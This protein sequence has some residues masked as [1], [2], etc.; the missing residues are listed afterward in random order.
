MNKRSFILMLIVPFL[1]ALN[2]VFGKVLVD[3]L[4]PYTI[5]AGRFTVA[6]IIFGLWIIFRK[7]RLPRKDPKF[8]LTLVLISLAS[9]V[10]YNGTLYLGLSYTTVVNGTIVNSFNPIATMILAAVILKERASWQ[11]GV[12]AVLSI[13]GVFIIMSG[14]SLSSLNKFNIGDVIIFFNT[15]VWAL[16]SVLG[17]KVMNVLSPLESIA[18]TT[19]MGLP[20]LWIISGIE[21]SFFPVY[22]L[23]WPA[24]F[25]I[26]FLGV[27]ASVIAF[28]WWY[29]GIK[30][31]G[32][33][34]ASIFYN[35]IPLYALIISSVFLG[36]S[37]FAFHIIGCVLIIGGIFIASQSLSKA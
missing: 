6:G 21:L 1:W 22:S 3:I 15:F 37:I 26:I 4:P 20:L 5:A 25:L 16:F 17:K 36:E 18:F 34:G 7:K 28:V 19:L 32:A 13:L 35:L 29:Q 33:S 14:G 10:T 12:G 2:F 23:P 31:F 9:I 27:F 11:Q 8:I 30:D 24:V